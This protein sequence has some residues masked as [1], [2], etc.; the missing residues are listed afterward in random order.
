M[1]VHILNRE[2]PCQPKKA[3]FAPLAAMSHAADP[4]PK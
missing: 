1:F 2:S 3:F 4:I